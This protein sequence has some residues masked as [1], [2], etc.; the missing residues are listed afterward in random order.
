MTQKELLYLEDAVGHETSIIKILNEILGMLDDEELVVFIE[1]EIEK[2][3]SL[4]DGLL[5]L[6]EDKANG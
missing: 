4:K 5:D 6:L 3:N 2:H 1:E